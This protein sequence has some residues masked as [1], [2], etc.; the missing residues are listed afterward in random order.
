MF[1]LAKRRGR[2][3]GLYCGR[4]GVYLGSAALIVR[5]EGR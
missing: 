3:D 1:K 5:R 2:R 4:D